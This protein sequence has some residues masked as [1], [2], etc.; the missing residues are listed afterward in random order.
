MAE[1]RLEGTSAFIRST[2]QDGLQ[3]PGNT[4]QYL[5][6]FK[7][8]NLGSMASGITHSLNNI[9]GGILGYAQLLKEELQPNSDQLRQITVIEQAAKRAST[10]ISQIQ[11]YS[12][13]QDTTRRPVDPRKIV[14]DIVAILQSAS[15]KDILVSAEYAHAGARVEVNVGAICHALLNICINGLQAM[16]GEGEL[17]IR[18]NVVTEVGKKKKKSQLLI[19]EI[20]DTGEGIAPAAQERLFEPFYS[21]QSSHRSVG[22]GLP[23]ARSI[24][25]EHGGRLDW[26]SDEQSGTTFVVSLPVLDYSAS[27]H[28]G[29]VTQAP[30]E[31]SS[32]Q[33]VMI[34]DDEYD[35]RLL[36]KRL[37][38]KRGYRVLLADSGQ[39]AIEVFEK[40]ASEIG[41]VILDMIMPGFDGRTVFEKLK[42]TRGD[43][44]F[45]LTSGH[46]NIDSF[47]DI[48]LRGDA[49]FVPKPWDLPRLLDET[50]LALEKS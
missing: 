1:N 47:Q 25:E 30:E 35:L 17:K 20:S 2:L 6:L 10:L 42:N 22:L 44:H 34:V 19:I 14:D 49:V 9:L 27:P 31:A 16:H 15:T 7:L 41:V 48:L 12:H 18:T 8:A 32:K 26:T 39:S 46:P 36:G 3:D 13:S 28:S 38:E 11:F 37:L 21:S 43:C 23:I 45:I 5:K 33:I 50:E 40:N 4:E 24:F 29:K